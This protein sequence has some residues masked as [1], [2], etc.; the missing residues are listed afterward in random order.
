[1]RTHTVYNMEQCEGIRKDIGF[2]D[3]RVL[4]GAQTIV[5]RYRELESETGLKLVHTR[6]QRSALYAPTLDRIVMP[7]KNRF[8]DHSHYYLTA[9]HE[10]A[11]STGHSRRINRRERDQNYNH[12]HHSYGREELVAEMAA[13]LIALEPDLNFEDTLVEDSAAY[14]KGWLEALKEDP[15]ML[16]RAAPQAQTAFDYVLDRGNVRESVRAE[17]ERRAR[18]GANS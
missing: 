8:P 2:Q 17:S 1:M 5:D 3:T 14:L 15:S 12:G 10:I 4:P 6:T 16:R 13:S 9:F 18:D 7:F 11:H